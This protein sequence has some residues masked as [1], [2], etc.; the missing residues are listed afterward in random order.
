MERQLWRLQDFR[1]GGGFGYW[2]EYFFLVTQQHLYI[3][4]SPEAHSAMIVG[5]LRT[6]TSNWRQYKHS[7]GTQRV[8][9]NLVC[10]LA[11]LGYGLLSDTAFPKYLTN[12]LLI[13]LGNMV[14]GQSGS[15]ID[16][17][18]KKM[19]DATRTQEGVPGPRWWLKIHAFRAE[20]MKV[21]SRSRAPAP[22][23]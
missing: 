19:E 13:L 23:S 8:I 7:I 22:S 16:D 15:H 2:V 3:P 4:L 21:I 1:D 14:E 10:D 11:I 12:E 6:I 9:L 20:A 18:M 17:A 5:T